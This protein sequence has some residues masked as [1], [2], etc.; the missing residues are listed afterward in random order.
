[1]VTL[2]FG[3]LAYWYFFTGTGNDAPLTADATQNPAQTQFKMLVSELGPITFNTAIFTDPRFVG[4]S[5]L[6]TPISPE[7][8]GR[9]DPFATIPG[10]RTNQ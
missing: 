8:P 6:A 2:L 9:L 10:L 7:T 5:D 1:M 4:L 3:G